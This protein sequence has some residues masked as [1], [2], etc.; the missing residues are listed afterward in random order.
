M[1]KELLVLTGAVCLTLALLEAWMLVV[2][3]S[4]P[5]AA[6]AKWIRE[7][8]D[9]L[10]SHIDFLLMSQFLFVF[11]LLFN[12]FQVKASAFIILSMCLGSLGNP[13]LFLIRAAK[14]E[15]KDEPSLGFRLMMSSSC[16]LTTMGYLG[17]AWLVGRAAIALI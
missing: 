10:K 5:G 4:N 9:L 11:Y 8:R 13:L 7:S 14:P 15:W 1:V 16:L 12:H 6:L 2:L 17:G 3:S